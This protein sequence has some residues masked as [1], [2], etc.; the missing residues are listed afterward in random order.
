MP[1]NTENASFT[2]R[3]SQ[4]AEAAARVLRGMANILEGDPRRVVTM[5][6]TIT[7]KGLAQPPE[8]PAN[9]AEP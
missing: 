3:P 5:T 7:W 9:Q 2:L 6:L 4:D 8:P 1:E